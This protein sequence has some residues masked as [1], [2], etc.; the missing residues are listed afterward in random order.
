MAIRCAQQNLT[1]TKAQE[2]SEENLETTKALENYTYNK[3]N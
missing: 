1:G 2:K 3:T